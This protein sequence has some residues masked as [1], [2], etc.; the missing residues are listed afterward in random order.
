MFAT[1][2]EMKKQ[3]NIFVPSVRKQDSLYRGEN[4]RQPG[5]LSGSNLFFSETWGTVTCNP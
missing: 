5:N 1:A 4:T 2:K 3:N